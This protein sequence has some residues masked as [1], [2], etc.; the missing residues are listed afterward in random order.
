MTTPKIPKGLIY[1]AEG[2]LDVNAMRTN[3]TLSHE[4][5]IKW[6]T[7][8]VDVAR[9]RLTFVQDLIDNG[10]V[11]FVG[12]DTHRPKYVEALEKSINSKIFKTIEEKNIIKNVYL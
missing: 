10:L 8:M 6:D 5:Y 9:T 4:D 7:K 2:R 1:N 3:G 12:S 11:D